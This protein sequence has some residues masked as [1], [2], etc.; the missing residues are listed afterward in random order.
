MIQVAISAAYFGMVSVRG[1]RVDEF[2][3]N[4]ATKG[5]GVTQVAGRVEPIYPMWE[6]P[7][8]KVAENGLWELFSASFPPDSNLSAWPL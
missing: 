6:V 4:H 2:L 3:G 5:L 8:V 7:V 1:K